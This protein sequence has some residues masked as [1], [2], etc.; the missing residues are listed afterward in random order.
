MNG[1]H[2]LNFIGEDTSALKFDVTGHAF[3]RP[4]RFKTT[5]QIRKRWAAGAAL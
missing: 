1:R 3:R 4:D 5:A 2:A